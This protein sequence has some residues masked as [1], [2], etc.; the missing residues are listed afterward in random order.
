MAILVGL[1]EID[2]ER[3]YAEGFPPETRSGAIDDMPTLLQE[4]ADIRKGG[5]ALNWEE[6][7]DGVVASG[8]ALR[9]TV[10]QPLAAIGVAAP[11][12]WVRAPE[13]VRSF[14]P[15]LRRGASLVH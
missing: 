8:V 13:S 15:G 6:S 2:F 9:H 7:A 11:S 3:R 5:Y 10:R 14:A 4:L 1:N 12:S